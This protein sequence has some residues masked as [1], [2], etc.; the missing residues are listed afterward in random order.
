MARRSVEWHG[1]AEANVGFAFGSVSVRT[2]VQQAVFEEQFTSP[3][4]IRL[5]GCLNFQLDR[6]LDNPSTSSQV[7]A[8]HVGII[9]AHLALPVSNLDPLVEQGLD[10]LWTC[11]GCMAF[12]VRNNAGTLS[13]I[14]TNLTQFYHIDSRAMR[15]VRDDQRLMLLVNPTSI[16]GGDSLELTYNLRVLIKD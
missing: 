11:S 3:M 6:T 4:I 9:V 14:G 15:K 12:P 7:I 1:L 8:Y 16:A 10:W 13:D 2:I 5:E